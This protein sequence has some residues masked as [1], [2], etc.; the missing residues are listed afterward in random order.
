MRASGYSQ[1]KITDALR[2]SERRSEAKREA[3]GDL[4]W[5]GCCAAGSRRALLPVRRQDASP[6]RSAPVPPLVLLPRSSQRPAQAD[7]VI[8]SHPLG[9]GVR[10]RPRGD[11]TRPTQGP[12]TPLAPHNGVSE[13]VLTFT[14]V[15]VPG[16]P[17]RC[18]PVSPPRLLP[19]NVIDK[20]PPRPDAVLADRVDLH[21]Q[22]LDPVDHRGAALEQ[23][24]LVLEAVRQGP[25][26]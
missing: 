10:A 5:G 6:Q 12:P 8:E 17:P 20:N 25:P 13:A 19:P 11:N 9:G 16:Y 22:A 14:A 18:G 26:A 23:A 3:W 1:F 7:S 4:G 21:R 15:T 24:V 2:R